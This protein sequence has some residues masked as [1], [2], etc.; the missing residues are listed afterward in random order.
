L[1]ARHRT[2]D[3]PDRNEEYLIYQTLLGAWPLEPWGAEE[4]DAFVQRVQAYLVKAMREAK[5]N[6]S[7]TSPNEAHEKAVTDFIAKILAEP[8]GGAFLADL[9]PF[10]QRV[11][12][13]GLVNSLA[14]TVLRL[15]A[16]GVPD[17]YQ[18]QEL[19]DFSLVDPDNRRPVDYAKRRQML[20]GLNASPAD[21]MATLED[22]R[23]KMFVTS[24]L[25]QLRRDNPG[26]FT[27]GEYVPL[28]AEGEHAA[29]VFAFA[30]RH[31]GKTAVVVIPRLASKLDAPAAW[32]DTVLSLPPGSEAVRDVF[33]GSAT[34]SGN[35]VR[36]SDVL[37]DLPVAVLV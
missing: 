36:I 5:V 15:T 13:L 23:P 28:R 31:E 32:G 8:T 33:T 10:R 24:R 7:W 12:K 29:N 19:W 26:L 6:T 1:N 25:L 17:T 9:R 34:A 35:R 21:L 20:D 18:G 11:S 2:G 16:P 30:R 22:G 27:A 14:Q 3:V 4:Y 37:R